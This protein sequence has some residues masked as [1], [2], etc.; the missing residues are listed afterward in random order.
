MCFSICWEATNFPAK[1]FPS[2]SEEA[3]PAAGGR[4]QV[5]VWTLLASQRGLGYSSGPGDF[6]SSVPSHSG[7]ALAGLPPSPAA[8]QLMPHSLGLSAGCRA[9]HV[10]VGQVVIWQ[11]QLLGYLGRCVVEAD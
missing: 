7:A 9:V 6:R 2:L 11:K 1:E 10:F 8:V 4:A 5:V 3:Q